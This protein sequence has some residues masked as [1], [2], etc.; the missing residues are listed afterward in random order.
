M[1]ASGREDGAE[2]SYNNKIM[3]GKYWG[4]FGG[5]KIDG[6]E[7][8]SESSRAKFCESLEDKNVED[9]LN[10]FQRRMYVRGFTIVSIGFGGL[11]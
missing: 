1:G 11:N 5:I 3:D 2:M 9:N 10:D 6:Y 4:D 7:K 8:A